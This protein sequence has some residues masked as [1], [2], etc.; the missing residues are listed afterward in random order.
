MRWVGGGG[1]GDVGGG[2]G[3]VGGGGEG[4]L[5]VYILHWALSLYICMYF[6]T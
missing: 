3:D 6:E 4:D 5:K 2:D 1:N